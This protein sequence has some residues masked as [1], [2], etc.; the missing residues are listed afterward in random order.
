MLSALAGIL[1]YGLMQLNGH[2]GLAGWRWYVFICS[3][4]LRVYR[5]TFVRCRIFIL[6]GLLTCVVGLLGFT[7]LVK[8]PDQEVDKPSP[9]F[10]RLE[11]TKAIIAHL[12]HDRGDVTAEPFSLKSFLKPAKE[13][14][15]WAFAFL[16][17]YAAA[18][19]DIFRQSPNCFDQT[20]NI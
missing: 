19:L 12:N 1:A 5:L 7:V 13:I 9:W 4:F 18:T 11:E 20:V 14:E 2:A 3:M 15:I 6:E 8:F 10:L 17:L 16:F